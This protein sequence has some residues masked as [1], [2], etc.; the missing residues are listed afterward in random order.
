MVSEVDRLIVG[1]KYEYEWNE[2]EWNDIILATLGIILIKYKK[3]GE[4]N[5]V[6]EAKKK[7]MMMR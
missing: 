7:K 2:Y 1:D 5:V 6:C 3:K 4:K